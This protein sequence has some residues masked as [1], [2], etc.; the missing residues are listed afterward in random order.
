[1]RDRDRRPSLGEPL[2]RLLHE[3]LRL[4][5]ERRGRL[6]EDEDRRVAQDRARDRD[7][8]LLAAREAVAALADHRVVALRERRDQL[9]DLRRARRLLDLLVGRVGRAKR[10]FSRTV[11]WKRYVSCETTPTVSVSD[12]NV[13]SRTSTP[14]IDTVPSRRVV[15]ARD[16][17]RARRLARARLAD[18]RRLRPRRDREGHVLQRPGR[19][20]VAEPDRVEGDLAARARRARVPLDDV[21]LVVE[22]LEDAVEERERA[23]APRSGRRGGCR[24]GRRGVSAGW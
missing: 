3:P 8:L 11:A 16:E 6:V 10:R 14:S 2:E 23:S 17:V 1:M 5:V 19:V 22:V 18:E 4:R 12:S 24:S 9:V 7:P 20:V 21:D 15:E 13:R